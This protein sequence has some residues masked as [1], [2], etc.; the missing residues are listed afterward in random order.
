MKL[1]ISTSW[2]V[3]NLNAFVQCNIEDYKYQSM[4]NG[5]MEPPRTPVSILSEL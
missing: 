5:D 3:S 1:K 2:P 4:I